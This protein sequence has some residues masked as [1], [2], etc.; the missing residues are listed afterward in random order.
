MNTA[1][2]S[3]ASSPMSDAEEVRLAKQRDRAVWA[4]WHDRHYNAIYRYAFV[5]L[6]NQEDAEDL[7][8][9]VF[10]EAL[11]GIDRYAYR[12]RPILAWLYG[13]AGNLVLKRK[14]EAARSW[15]TR[16]A[17]A[18]IED[19]REEETATLQRLLVSDLLNR[20]KKEHRDALVLRYLLDLPTKDVARALNKSEA[21][22]YS[23]LFRALEAA[24]AVFSRTSAS[25]E[26]ER[27]AARKRAG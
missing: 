25:Q 13:I 17:S 15:A 14:R 22:T 4:A 10:L 21:A 6:G 2:G 23:L 20:L 18:A 7:A 3:S 26:S 8:S 5:R 11:K 24:H 9:Q 12:E 16:E 27:L 19:S 1:E